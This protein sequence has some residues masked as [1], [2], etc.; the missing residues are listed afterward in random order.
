MICHETLLTTHPDTG[1]FE[2]PER[3]ALQLLGEFPAGQ[4]PEMSQEGD[5]HPLPGHALRK[6]GARG[7]SGK[8]KFCVEVLRVVRG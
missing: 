7:K 3:L 8:G 1:A 5:D 2:G 6:R 4:V